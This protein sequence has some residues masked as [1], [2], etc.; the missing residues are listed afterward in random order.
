MLGLGVREE[1]KDDGVTVTL[2]LPGFINT[3]MSKAMTYPKASPEQVAERSLD[4][5]LSGQHT[6]W[7]DRFSELVAQ[8]IGSPMREILDEPREVMN[9][10]TRTFLDAARVEESAAERLTEQLGRRTPTTVVK[11]APARA[12]DGGSHMTTSVDDTA[13]VTATMYAFAQGIDTRDWE[14]LESQ[15][16][17]PFELD[18]SSHRAGSTGI[19]T[20][21]EWVAR[22]RRR[23]ETMKATQ[24]SM[25]NP[26]VLIDGDTARCRMYI[27][28][29]HVADLDGAT[30]WCTIGGEYHNQL[31]RADGRWIISHLEL[32]R[33]WT[34]G[35]PA[36]LDL[37]VARD[38]A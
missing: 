16:A 5:W 13:G 34:I 11:L 26:R 31:V 9:A 35:N 12:G 4:G 38:P 24:H 2:S 18:Y 27:E 30:E 7:P 36:V 10:V 23:F 17:D 28:A 25:T 1:L 22:A 15:F 3:E 19:V 6:V 32:E 8:Q 33:R 37:P 29:W 21:S 14:L 20:P